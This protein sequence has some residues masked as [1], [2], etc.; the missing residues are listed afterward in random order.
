MYIDLVGDFDVQDAFALKDA[1]TKL[2]RRIE[3]NTTRKVDLLINNSVCKKPTS[4]ARKIFAKMTEDESVGKIAIYGY[5]PVVRVIA[6]FVI[7]FSK[8]KNIKIFNS[9]ESSLAWLK[10]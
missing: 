2:M 1:S 3:G 5:N 6:S 7:G 10:E 8:N 4:E 9:K